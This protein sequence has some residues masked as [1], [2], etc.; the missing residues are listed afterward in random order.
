MAGTPP[1]SCCPDCPEVGTPDTNGFWFHL[2]CTDPAS[3]EGD[4]FRTAH[5]C[6]KYKKADRCQRCGISV[7]PTEADCRQFYRMMTGPVAKDNKWKFVAVAELA[8]EHGWVMPTRGRHPAHHT[9]WPAVEVEDR[10]SLFTVL[11]GELP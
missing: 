11:P 1:H 8:P 3:T 4:A 6:D 10:C 5:E 7:F 9:W 2:C